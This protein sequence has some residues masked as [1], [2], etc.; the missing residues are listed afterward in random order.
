MNY[1]P[2]HLHQ[3]IKRDDDL[4]EYIRSLPI[5]M[6]INKTTK[7]VDKTVLQKGMEALGGDWVLQENNYFII[8][9]KIEDTPF[10]EINLTPIETED[11]N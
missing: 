2:I 11:K 10:E 7:E 1:R 5:S 9:K 3:L 4:F 6:F 8:C